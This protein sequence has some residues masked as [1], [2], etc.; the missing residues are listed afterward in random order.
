MLELEKGFILSHLAFAQICKLSSYGEY[1]MNG[2]VINVCK[3][4]NK[5]QSIL[6]HLP[7]DE[8]IMCVYLKKHFE[9]KSHYML[10][11]VCPNM[12]MITIQ[13]LI[14]TPKI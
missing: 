7:H 14:E 10:G 11:N 5:T 6:P 9:Y 3:N 1:K 12:V 2:I 4:V 13:D 8:T